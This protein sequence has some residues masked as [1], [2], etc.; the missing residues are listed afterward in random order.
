[1]GRLIAAV[2]CAE[3]TTAAAATL[4]WSAMIAIVSE[5]RSIRSELLVAQT[6][7]D[8]P[9]AQKESKRSTDGRHRTD[10]KKP[11]KGRQSSTDFSFMLA[12]DPKDS[13]AKPPGDPPAHQPAHL[14]SF[15]YIPAEWQKLCS[16]IFF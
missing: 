14:L 16:L 7:L 4:K 15:N 13:A 2:R 5:C 6:K 8:Q 11:C 10:E 1:M 12:N 3:S 9:A